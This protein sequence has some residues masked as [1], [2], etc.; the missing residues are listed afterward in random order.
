MNEVVTNP[1]EYETSGLKP[2]VSMFNNLPIVL[3]PGFALGEADKAYVDAL[4][5]SWE[6]WCGSVP[7]SS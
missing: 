7:H 1:Q 2:I 5:Y 3:S 6:E 4:W